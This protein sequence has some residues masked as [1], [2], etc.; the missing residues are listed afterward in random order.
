MEQRCRGR[1]STQDWT[2]QE[3]ILPPTLQLE[4]LGP[5]EEARLESSGERQAEPGCAVPHSGSRACPGIILLAAAWTFTM[6]GWQ[7]V[8]SSSEQV[9]FAA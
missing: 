1:C 6:M 8:A 9:F 3:T 4:G 7:G 5:G 2:A